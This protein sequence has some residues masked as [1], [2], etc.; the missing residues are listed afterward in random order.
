MRPRPKCLKFNETKNIKKYYI[1]HSTSCFCYKCFRETFI[2]IQ[3]GLGK[4]LFEVKNQKYKEQ[5]LE[6]LNLPIRVEYFSSFTGAW[7]EWDDLGMNLRYLFIDGR[8][9]HINTSC[10][11]GQLVYVHLLHGWSV[12]RVVVD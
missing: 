5:L 7:S 6:I 12:S 2:K 9:L 1:K 11:V 3:D 8:Y 4:T 10:F